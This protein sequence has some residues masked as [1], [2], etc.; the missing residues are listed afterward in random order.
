MTTARDEYEFEAECCKPTYL[1]DT[2][3]WMDQ[4][5]NSKKRSIHVLKSFDVFSVTFKHCESVFFYCS[6][7]SHFKL[8]SETEMNNKWNENVK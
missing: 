4:K 8:R 1:K 6:S 3:T 2:D 5:N 7:F